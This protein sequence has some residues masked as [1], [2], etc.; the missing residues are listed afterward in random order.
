MEARTFTVKPVIRARLELVLW[1]I[2]FKEKTRW[3]LRRLD[4]VIDGIILN[5]SLIN[6]AG[7]NFT[8][9]FSVVKKLFLK[10]RDF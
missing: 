4:A 5:I 9:Q 8:G 6:T 2:A 10:K 3:S 7:F 1:V